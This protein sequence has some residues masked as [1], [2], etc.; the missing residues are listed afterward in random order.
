MNEGQRTEPSQTEER[1]ATNPKGPAAYLVNRYLQVQDGTTPPDQVLLLVLD[2]T[3]SHIER[4][5]ERMAA[6]DLEAKH[7]HLIK[8]QTIV[9]ELRNSLQRSIGEELHRQICG[10]YFFIYSKLV[11]GNVKNDSALLDEALAVVR[12]VRETW[13][14]AVAAYRSTVGNGGQPAGQDEHRAE[15]AGLCVQC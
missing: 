6:G 2:G 10:L 13:R 7:T 8:A 14:Q 15:G 3:V 4:A 11:E 9:L 5:R 1:P 12:E